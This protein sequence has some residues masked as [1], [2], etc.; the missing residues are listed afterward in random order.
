MAYM[1]KFEF[2][3]SDL[4]GGTDYLSVRAQQE[5]GVLGPVSGPQ[6]G[7]I[8]VQLKDDNSAQCEVTLYHQ[9]EPAYTAWHETES[10]IG[11]AGL[12]RVTDV[13][14]GIRWILQALFDGRIPQEVDLDAMTKWAYQEVF[15]RPMSK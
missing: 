3:L 1:Q 2:T 10:L 15:G 8:W 13:T 5:M 12:S 6:A 14:N 4:M 7:V 11:P 9:N